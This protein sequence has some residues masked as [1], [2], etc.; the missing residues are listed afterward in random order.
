MITAWL[1]I[2]IQDMATWMYPKYIYMFFAA[3]LKAII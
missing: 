3:L 1:E 2:E